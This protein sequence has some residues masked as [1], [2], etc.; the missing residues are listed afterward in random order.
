VA[1]PRDL[2][3]M[4]ARGRVRVWVRFDVRRHR[5]R[6]RQTRRLHLQPNRRYTTTR[7][8]RFRAR[9][10]VIARE[11]GCPRSTISSTPILGDDPVNPDPR[12]QGRLNRAPKHVRPRGNPRGPAFG[13]EGQRPALHVHL[14]RLDLPHKRRRTSTSPR[15]SPRPITGTDGRPRARRGARRDYAGSYC[16]NMGQGRPEPRGLS[17]RRAVGYLDTGFN[18]EGK[19]NCR[20]SADETG[21]SRQLEGRRWKQLLGTL[22]SPTSHLSAP[23]PDPLSRPVRGLSPS[24]QSRAPTARLCHTGTRSPSAR[25]DKRPAT[26]TDVER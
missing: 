24:D 10:A 14:S 6:Y 12:G 15:G 8:S 26:C 22:H 21:S 3:I 13:D 4:T 11:P 9:L 1:D 20:R 19:R 2:A 25:D 23:G 17:G 5:P 7:W 18:T 16:E